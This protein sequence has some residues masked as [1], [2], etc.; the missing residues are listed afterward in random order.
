MINETRQERLARFLDDDLGRIARHTRFVRQ[1]QS[2]LDNEHEL[3]LWAIYRDIQFAHP[4]LTMSQV[5]N[6]GVAIR[7]AFILGKRYGD[8]LCDCSED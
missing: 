2:A 4:E 8:D 7:A 5:E 3:Q 1:R 6:I